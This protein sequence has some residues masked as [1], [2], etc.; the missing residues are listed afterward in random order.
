MP[1]DPIRRRPELI[2]VTANVYS[3]VDFAIS[4][5]LFVVTQDS[6]VVI[7][8]TESIATARACL[9]EFR[10]AC[11]LPIRRIIYTHFHGDHIRGAVAFHEPGTSVIAQ[12]RMPEELAKMYRLFPQK[13]RLNALQFGFSLHPNERSISLVGP[14]EDGYIVPDILVEEEY[15]F[16]QGGVAFDLYHTQGE[17]VD[18]LMVWLPEEKVLFPGDLFYSAFPMLS[19]PLK[20]DRPVVAWADSLER[21]RTFRPEHLAPSHSRP[22]HGVDHI[23]SVLAN[24]AR[25]IRYVNDETVKGINRAM[26]LEEIQRWIHP[27]EK[28]MSLPYLRQSYG[29]LR[30]AVNGI[31]RQYTG[32][33][34][35]NPEDLRPTSRAG[36]DLALLQAC[37]GSAPIVKRARRAL[38]SGSYQLAL[39]LAVVVL[40]AQPH[41][42][43]ATAIRVQALQR[44][45][46]NSDNRVERNIYLAAAKDPSQRPSRI[47][48]GTAFPLATG[49]R[50]ISQRVHYQKQSTPNLA[51]QRR[52]RVPIEKKTTID[53]INRLYDRRMFSPVLRPDGNDDFHNWGYWVPGIQRRRAASENLMEELLSFLPRKEGTILDVACGKG[54]TTRYLLKYYSPERVTGINIS[55]KQLQQCRVNAPGCKF[56]CMDASD[57]AF[58]GE[59]FDN[60][61]CV[62]AAFHF[63]TRQEFLLEAWRVLKP[64]GR[65]ILSDVLETMSGEATILN[66]N[67]ANYVKNL[68][69]YRD[70]YGRAGFEDLN[71]VD[72]T[73]EC[74]HSFCLYAKKLL[75]Q[76]LFEQEIG[77]YIFRLANDFL[78]RRSREV[79]F[80]LLVSA[81]KPISSKA[82]KLLDDSAVI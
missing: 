60:I 50:K 49:L 20:P 21:M 13:R 23:D 19:N 52:R 76:R 59:V 57:L 42:H 8:T 14:P 22:R 18:H 29:T 30:W 12:K 67:G 31:Y 77:P 25:M 27:P 78:R 7:D 63:H 65:L 28:L 80:Y 32:W 4:N 9:D 61:I 38:K 45:A 68:A 44:L 40:N 5:A 1:M 71:C 54:A 36:R 26:T 53:A 16:E 46:K 6:V 56:L 48:P 35:L 10:K 37:G 81:V 3:A 62:E 17:T 73:R 39:E 82:S 74:F 47:P 33:Y 43:N 75:R 72:A 66:A 64:G 58:Q 34:T 70:L 11:K 51:V 2:K 15:H 24:Y 41:N 55:E 69:E 79:R